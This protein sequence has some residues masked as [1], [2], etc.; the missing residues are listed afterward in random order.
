M[1]ARR[2]DATVKIGNFAAGGEYLVLIDG[3]CWARMKSFSAA[4][5]VAQ[6]LARAEGRILES[7]VEHIDEAAEYEDGIAH[8]P[9]ITERELPPVFPG[10][11]SPFNT[12][13]FASRIGDEVLRAAYTRHHSADERRRAWCLRDIDMRARKLWDERRKP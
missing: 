2:D 8:W 3:C 9:N 4:R 1:S 10:S 6:A 7:D 12:V 11:W 13:E 5:R